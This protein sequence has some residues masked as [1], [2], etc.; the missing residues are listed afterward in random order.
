MII[1]GVDYRSRFPPRVSANCFG[2]YRDRRVSGKTAGASRG[3]G[4]VLPR[5]G[6]CGAAG[7]SWNG[8]Q[9]ACTLVRTTAGRVAG[10]DVDWRRG[11]DPE[12][13]NR[14]TRDWAT[15]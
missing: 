10:R 12:Q 4:E 1:I 15:R 8:S 11:R 14:E 5:S 6:G 9:W 7:T 13:K 3:G 2:G